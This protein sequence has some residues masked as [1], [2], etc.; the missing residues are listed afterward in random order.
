MKKLTVR[1]YAELEVPD[2]W[3]IVEVEEGVQVLKIDGTF[4][5]FDITPLA[6]NSTGPDAT[7]SDE[8]DE[9]TATILDTVIGLDTELSLE[10]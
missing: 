2:D 7:W 8:D 5:D 4:V 10:A 9:L 6:S 3:E 1:I